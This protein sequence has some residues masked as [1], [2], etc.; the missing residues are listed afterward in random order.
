MNGIPNGLR[1]V[2]GTFL[3]LG[4]PRGRELVEIRIVVGECQWVV[5][6]VEL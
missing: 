4:R 6:L 1:V 3:G 2:K 5:G